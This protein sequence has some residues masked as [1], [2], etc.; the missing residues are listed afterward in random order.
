MCLD[1]PEP[2]APNPPPVS[3]LKPVQE[4]EPAKKKTSAKKKA[5]AGTGAL[6]IPLINLTTP[7]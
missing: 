3:T 5:A 1:I 2:P 7:K 4:T 6:Q